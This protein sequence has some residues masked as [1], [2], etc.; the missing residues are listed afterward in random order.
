[1]G[2]EPVR[3]HVE[4]HVLGCAVD[5]RSDHAL[6]ERLAR[7]VDFEESRVLG[8]LHHVAGR[9]HGADLDPRVHLRPRASALATGA[10]LPARATTSAAATTL[11]AAALGTTGA[12]GAPGATTATGTTAPTTV[13]TSPT[14][15]ARRFA[16]THR[17]QDNGCRRITPRRFGSIGGGS[18][19]VARR[20]CGARSHGYRVAPARTPAV[21]GR[22][23]RPHGAGRD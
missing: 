15:P 7:R 5:P 4:H 11:G 16:R 6:G 10:A 2:E 14:G 9:D 21:A 3:T 23:L 8:A 17:R 22:V 19:G 12:T 18:Q 20:G 13:G 1:M